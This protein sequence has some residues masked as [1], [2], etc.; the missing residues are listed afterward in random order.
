MIVSFQNTGL[1]DIRAVTTFGVSAKEGD[2]PIGYFGTGL[3]YAIAV[4]LRSGGAVTIWR[5]LDRY[6]FGLADVEVRGEEFRIITMRGYD[7]VAPDMPSLKELGFTTR[8]GINW[9]GWQAFREIYCNTIDERGETIMDRVGHEPKEGFTTIHV[10]GV[11][12]F[13]ESYTKRGSIVLT[14]TPM[15][16]ME[17]V[18]V[19]HGES[20]HLYY[21]GIL[22]GELVRGSRY[23]YNV[24]SPLILTEDRTI[25]HIH[26]AHIAIAKAIVSCDDEEFV[27]EWLQSPRDSFEHGLDLAYGGDPS[28]AFL[29]AAEKAVNIP[30]RPLN[31]S[32]T[33]LVARHRKVQGTLTPAVLDSVQTAQLTKAKEVCRKLGYEIDQHPIIVVKSLGVGI[34]GSTQTGAI[35]LSQRAFDMG[36][37]TVAGT[38]LEEHLH[39][40]FQFNDESRDFQNYLIDAL[41][42]AAERHIYGEAL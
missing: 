15:R 6:E 2:S 40:A 14:K 36:T 19:H 18:D 33:G 7:P 5:G 10:S 42:T 13:E 38:I 12:D 22:A 8:L 32:T 21:R 26:F 31:L 9:E 29:N 34:L 24:L 28:E 39:L 27:L 17:G 37:K 35:V 30:D 20:N 3:K 11:V 41:I 23:C 25:K 1:I 16:R 4:I